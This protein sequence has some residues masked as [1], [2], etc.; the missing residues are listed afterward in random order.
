MTTT[1]P[2]LRYATPAGRWVILATVLGSGMAFLD[3]TV[4]NIALPR[5]GEDLDASL[6]GLQWTVNAYTLTL[7]AFLLPGGALG[8]RLGR[9]RIFV[10]GTALFAAASALCALAP[11][12]ETLVAARALQGVGGA[13]LM[14][15]SLAIIEATFHRDDRG[16]AIGAWSG[17]AGV[18]AAIGPFLGGWL[19]GAASWRW[20]FLINLPIAAAVLWVAA[21]H[22]PETRDPAAGGGPLD[23]PGATL[24]ALGLAGVTWGLTAASG[25]GWDAASGGLAA[26]G[27]AC[28][29]AF[30]AVEARSR[31][32]MVPPDIWASRLFTAANAVTF[33]LYAALSGAL[34]L[35]P[36]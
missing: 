18:A 6:T 12:V 30:A 25:S 36:I 20:V 22:V 15:A 34:F 7:A 33:V 29:A 35:L 13:L 1:A 32:P 4:V 9:R 27:A 14:P 3:G 26:A 31:H 21:R 28:L 16:A 11:T 24:A 2:A 8:D 23:V 17:L 19:V 10:A 5:I